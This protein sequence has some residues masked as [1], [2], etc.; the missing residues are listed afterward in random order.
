MSKLHTFWFLLRNTFLLTNMPAVYSSHTKRFNFHI[1]ELLR[2]KRLPLVKHLQ[3]C[4]GLK[5]SS[6]VTPPTFLIL[7][8]QS[9]YINRNKSGVQQSCNTIISL[10]MVQ[11]FIIIIIICKHKTWNRL[12]KTFS[13]KMSQQDL[14]TCW[15]GYSLIA[16]LLQCSS[17]NPAPISPVPPWN[18]HC[19]TVSLSLTRKF[20]TLCSPWI[21]FPPQQ[22][23]QKQKQ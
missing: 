16:F 3:I 4:I 14:N 13:I 9:V 20:T 1:L 2:T 21:V 11:A 8:N 12:S 7:Q 18:H 19:I 15:T 23:I 17:Q 10:D 5:F 22:Y 6:S